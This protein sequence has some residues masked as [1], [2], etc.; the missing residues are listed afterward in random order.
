MTGIGVPRLV[1]SKL[2]NHGEQSVT[3][4]YDRHSYDAEKR[5]ALLR[6]DRHL[7]QI[8]ANAKPEKVVALRG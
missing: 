4:V 3:A 8:L 6:W 1:V 5:A 2:L 7:Q